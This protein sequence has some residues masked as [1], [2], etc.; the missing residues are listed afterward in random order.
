MSETSEITPDDLKRHVYR[1]AADIGERNVFLLRALHAA[2]EYISQ[3]WQQQGYEVKRHPYVVNDVECANLE[4]TCPGSSASDECILIGAHYDSVIGSPGGNDNGSGV[5]ALLELSRLFTETSP[6]IDVRFVAFVNEEPP[7]YMWDKMGS[8]VYAKSARERGD[9]IRLMVSLETIGYYSDAPG[10]QQYPPLFK[11]LYPDRGDFVAFVSNLR[12]RAIMR[13]AV[14]AF[15]ANSNFPIQ[16][17]A[18]FEW[19]PGIAWSD[20]LSFWR[21]GYRA[22][23]VTDTAFYRYAYYHSAE[24]TA[25][26]LCYEPF[27][28]CCNGLYHCFS[29]LAQE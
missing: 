22:F 16:H 26:K 14:R 20:H 29:T 8:H 4:I 3:E 10:S 21:Q 27:A 13:K 12:S 6:A 5:A 28:Q 9:K 2:E 7:F 18:T 15:R 17:V 1:L 19:I 11:A 25:D 23:M 24:D